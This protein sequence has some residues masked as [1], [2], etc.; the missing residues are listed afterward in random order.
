M[1]RAALLIAILALVV[2]LPSVVVGEFLHYDDDHYVLYSPA[3]KNFEVA[4]AFDPRANRHDL[5]AEYLPVRDLTYMLDA[6][7]FGAHSPRA[8]RATSLAWYALSCALA[9]LLLAEVT[10]NPAASFL[11]AAFFAVHPVHAE[12]VAWIASRKDVVS[13]ALGLAALLL[14]ARSKHGGHLA[15]AVLLGA[16]A[17][18][19]K[20]TLLCLPLLVPLVERRLSWR[21]IPHVLVAALVAWNAVQVGRNTGIAH[22]LPPGG[23]ASILLTDAP[24]VVRYLA[25][26]FVPRGLRVCYAAPFHMT[27]E[28][29]V[30]ASFAVLAVFGLAAAARRELR[31]PALWFALAL[32][33]VLNLQPGSQWIAERYLFLPLLGPCLV[34][35][36]VL[37]RVSSRS[38]RLG[39]ALASVA[40]AA[41]ATLGVARG[42]DLAT[43]ERL[44][45]DNLRWTPDDPVVHHQLARGLLARA[46]R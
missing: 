18:L 29:I 16:A 31:L 24:I 7:L 1:M 17:M 26:S 2:Y 22:D 10:K 21:V 41:L 11:A 33:P 45:R 6:K 20:S 5:G 40:L 4:R 14:H 42:L 9:F 35:A 39:V 38:P 25:V 30:L 32:T 28:P 3:V 34:L 13:G 15:L 8:F 12:S 44:F 43:D 37:L 46:L 23:Y 36:R 27:L 19:S